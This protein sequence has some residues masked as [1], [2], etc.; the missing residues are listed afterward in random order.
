MV[1][2]RPM[3]PISLHGFVSAIPRR[4]RRRCAPTYRRSSVLREVEELDTEEI[5]KVL[6][7]TRTNLGVLLHRARARLR[8]CLENQGIRR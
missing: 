8:G 7:V 1:M 4:F 6:D 2:A 3:P 5:C